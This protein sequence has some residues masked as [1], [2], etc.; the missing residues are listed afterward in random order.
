[1]GTT[2]S[3]NKT[4]HIIFFDGVCNLCS[5]AVKFILKRDR[6][7]YFKFAP[8]QSA[9]AKECLGKLGFNNSL[10]TIVLF[11]NGKIFVKSDAALEVA[12]K[13]DFPWPLFYVF[14]IIPT[15]I[16]NWVYGF[17]SRNRYQWFGKSDEC[18]LPTPEISKRFVG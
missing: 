18:M 5:G 3:L 17:V 16:R 1:M 12:R 10:E 2:P 15:P 6:K 8:L 13:M 4:N 14:K 11:Q 7:H 9:V